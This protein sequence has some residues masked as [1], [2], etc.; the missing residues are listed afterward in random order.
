MISINGKRN[1]YSPEQ[2]GKTLTV[3]ELIEIL[4]GFEPSEKIYLK[5]DNGYT[6]G[7]ITEWDIE[8]EE[9]EEEDS[10]EE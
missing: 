7:S 5:N 6:W 3:E 8:E 10:E 2:T 4:Q 1:G 9:S